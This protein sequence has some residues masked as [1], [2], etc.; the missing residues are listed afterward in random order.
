M[1]YMM[2]TV[3]LVKSYKGKVVVDA[4]NIHVRKGE[5]YGFVGPNGA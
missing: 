1:D 2:E 5:I 3:N 4:V